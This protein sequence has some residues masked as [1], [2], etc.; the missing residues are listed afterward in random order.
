MAFWYEITAAKS[1]FKTDGSAHCYSTF[2]FK[3]SPNFNQGGKDMTSLH[4]INVTPE[5]AA[6]TLSIDLLPAVPT[7][8]VFWAY[9]NVDQVNEIS[10]EYQDLQT[11]TQQWWGLDLVNSVERTGYV[12]A[13]MTVLDSVL[14]GSSL[15]SRPLASSRSCAITEVQVQWKTLFATLFIVFWTLAPTIV[16]LGP[17]SL[18]SRCPPSNNQTWSQRLRLHSD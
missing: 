11:W 16:S 1:G 18:L 3:N 7:N 6:Y 10:T 13:Q 4:Q 12:I 9:H 2:K 5:E 17:P 15:F 14:H 8:L